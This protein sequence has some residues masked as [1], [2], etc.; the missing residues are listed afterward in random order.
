MKTKSL[1]AN[2]DF[3][4]RLFTLFGSFLC[5]YSGYVL[6]HGNYIVFSIFSYLL[7]TVL[8]SLIP[9]FIVHT[10]VLSDHKLIK[11]FTIL[12]L[13]LAWISFF[14]LLKPIFSIS[15]AVTF[16]FSYGFMFKK[17]Y[18]LASIEASGTLHRMPLFLVLSL[19][20]FTER[21]LWIICNIMNLVALYS[22]YV[23]E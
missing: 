8:I 1:L 20:N 19:T 18:E 3:T 6:L 15:F 16:T 5:L 7:S 4:N 23:V 12:L 2:I 13:I 17:K 9:Y 21:I 14:W 11:Q 10:K 22:Q